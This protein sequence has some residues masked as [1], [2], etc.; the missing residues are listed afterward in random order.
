MNIMCEV[1]KLFRPQLYC[2]QDKSPA[3][4]IIHGEMWGLYKD[5]NYDEVKV[6]RPNEVHFMSL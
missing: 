6:L 5:R 1:K 4:M 2:R 3:A